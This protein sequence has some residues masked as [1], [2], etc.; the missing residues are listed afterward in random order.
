[1]GLANDTGDR[2]RR[3]S[4]GAYFYGGGPDHGVLTSSMAIEP[5]TRSSS[6]YEVVY[7]TV[8][9]LFPDRLEEHSGLPGRGRELWIPCCM[10]NY[11]LT[12]LYCSRLGF[13]HIPHFLVCFLF[14]Y[15]RDGIAAWP[16]HFNKTKGI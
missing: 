7:E 2:Y 13:L 16:L 5:A 10:Y 4:P 9:V 15:I 3:F 1:M 11:S 14:T 8:F 12:T 6:H